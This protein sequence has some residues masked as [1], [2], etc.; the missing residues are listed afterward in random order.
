MHRCSRSRRVGSLGTPD[1]TPD[2]DGAADGADAPTVFPSGCRASEVDRP[3]EGAVG[4]PGGRAHQKLQTT[5][6][7]DGNPA[8]RVGA[9]L[10]LEVDEQGRW[11]SPILS[12]ASRRSADMR[13]VL[14]GSKPSR[15][16]ETLKPRAFTVSVPEPVSEA[17]DCMTAPPMVRSNGHAGEPQ[18]SPSER[19]SRPIRT[20]TRRKPGTRNRLRST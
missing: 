2:Q 20:E 14:L 9:G 19:L 15:V 11:A 12:S 6:E 8:D 17:L 16:A 5:L 13:P 3:G 10:V 4:F 7:L 1:Q 18:A